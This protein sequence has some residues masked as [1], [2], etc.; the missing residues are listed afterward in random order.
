MTNFVPGKIVAKITLKDGSSAVIRYPKWEDLDSLVTYVNQLSSE[1]TFVGLSGEKF[2]KEQEM[3][4][5]TSVFSK[6]ELQHGVTLWAVQDDQI[7]GICSVDKNFINRNRTSHRGGVGLS[8]K[9][10][11]RGFGIGKILL[12]ETIEQ[13]KLNLTGLKMLELTVFEINTKA[14]NLYQKLGFKI[15]GKI[16]GGYYYKGNYETQLQMILDL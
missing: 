1:D 7:I 15:V 16:E 9:S 8:I 4:F 11:Y 10:D 6:I 13:A 3:Q 2:S 12:T 14:V 5:L